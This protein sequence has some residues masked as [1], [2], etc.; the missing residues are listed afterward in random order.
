MLTIDE[1]CSHPRCYEPNIYRMV[2]ACR[3]CGTGDILVLLTAG[4]EAH[5]SA[6]SFGYRCPV[7]GCRDVR[8]SRL[9][10]DDE[11]PLAE[12]QSQESGG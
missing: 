1:R 3:N 12:S 7:C 10:T 11:F 6:S 9:A 5:G 8:V 2:G 4:H